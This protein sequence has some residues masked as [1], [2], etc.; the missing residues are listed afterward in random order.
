MALANG[1]TIVVEPQTKSLIPEETVIADMKLSHSLEQVEAVHV[2]VGIT[3]GIVDE[4]LVTVVDVSG[5]STQ[6]K[7][8]RSYL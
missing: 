3:T 6:S 4:L 1:L 5:G 2:A 7:Q 8:L